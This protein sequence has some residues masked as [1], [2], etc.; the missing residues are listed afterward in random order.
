MAG[1]GRH[2][3]VR[4]DRDGPKACARHVSNRML[5][6]GACCRVWLMETT[7]VIIRHHLDVSRGDTRLVQYVGEFGPKTPTAHIEAALE[8]YVGKKITR[9]PTRSPDP[10]NLALRDM[11][12]NRGPLF[13]APEWRLAA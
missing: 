8:V 9:A 5:L 12:G 2:P 10:L 11:P 13:G 4:L 1:N 3:K 7:G 6:I